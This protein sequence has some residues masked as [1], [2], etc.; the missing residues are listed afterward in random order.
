MYNRTCIDAEIHCSTCKK[1]VKKAI[2]NVNDFIHCE[3]YHIYCTDC[4]KKSQPCPQCNL[5]LQ[6]E[7]KKNPYYILENQD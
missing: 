1:L 2:F 3:L 7:E 5:P 4:K 6:Y